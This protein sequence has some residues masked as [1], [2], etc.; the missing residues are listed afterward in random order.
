MFW[1]CM[2][3]HIRFCAKFTRIS[4]KSIERRTIKIAYAILINCFV[5]YHNYVSLVFIIEMRYATMENTESA[6][7]W[8]K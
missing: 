2:T 5:G 4:S 6:L 7:G 3:Y 1:W 8:F